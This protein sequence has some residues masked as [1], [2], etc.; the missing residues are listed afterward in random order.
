[1]NSTLDSFQR[2]VLEGFFRLEKGFFLTGGAA[3]AGFHLGHRRTQDLDL[4]TTEDRVQAGSAALAATARDL[5]ASIESVQTYPDFRRYLLR[6]GEDALVVDLVR[7][8]APQLYSEKL[9]VNGIRVDPPEEILANKL[10]TLLSRSE[11]RDLVDVRALEHAG[12]PVERHFESASQKD[13]GLTPGQLAWVLSEVRIGEDAQPPG[14]VSV[15]EL[16]EYLEDLQS[17]L[18]RMAMPD[19]S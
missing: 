3:L 1:L 13:G 11:I 7:D 5:G 8:T 19:P 6:R 15:A 9:V 12:Y 16:R 17:R 4:F 18:S 10:C 2:E 14:G